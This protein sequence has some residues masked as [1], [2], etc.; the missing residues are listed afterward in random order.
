MSRSIILA[1]ALLVPACASTQP[2][3]QSDL[4]PVCVKPVG[5]GPEVRVL[6]EGEQGAGTRY[7]CFVCPIMEGKTGESWT[8]RAVSGLDGKS[9]VFHIKGDS[10]IAE[11]PTAVVLELPVAAGAECLEIHRVFTDPDEFRRYAATHPLASHVQPRTIDDVLR[12]LHHTAAPEK[13]PP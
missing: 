4:C 10:A 6:H 8:L 7:R 12:D 9:V 1:C 11:P 2:S 13:S 3:H 5:D